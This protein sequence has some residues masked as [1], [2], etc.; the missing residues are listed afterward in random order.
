M[1]TMTGYGIKIFDQSIWSIIG[2]PLVCE[3]LFNITIT[4]INNASEPLV[5]NFWMLSISYPSLVTNYLKIEQKATMVFSS[6]EL[7]A[8][9]C[10]NDFGKLIFQISR[11]KNGIFSFITD[12]AT[13]ITQFTQGNITSSLVQFRHDGR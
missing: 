7:N 8:T 11:I 13:P 1:Y 4:A 6:N 3:P 9:S 10:N 5:K 2:T 12:L